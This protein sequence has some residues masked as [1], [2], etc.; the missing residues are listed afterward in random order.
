LYGADEGGVG[1]NQV[2]E[3]NESANFARGVGAK[4]YEA[5]LQASEQ[6]ILSI[7]VPLPWGVENETEEN[8]GQEGR[9]D[10]VGGGVRN[11]FQEGRVVVAQY[12]VGWDVS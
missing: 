6:V 3:S 5:F 12:G 11:G 1:R 8:T 2:H 10:V 4:L 9:A 7:L